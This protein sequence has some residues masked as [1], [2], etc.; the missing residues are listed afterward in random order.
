MK[1]QNFNNTKHDFTEDDIN[2]IISII[3]YRCHIKTLNRLRSMLTYGKSAIP[4][5]GILERLTKED[6][7][8]S[9]CAGQDYS[10]EM[11]ILRDAILNK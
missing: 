4:I 3:G 8:W 1:Q 2:Q 11:K 6:N 7:T 9:Y 10:A 5:Y